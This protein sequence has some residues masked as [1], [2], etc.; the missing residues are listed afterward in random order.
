MWCRE[1]ELSCAEQPPQNHSCWLYR[2][3]EADESDLP[4]GVKQLGKS[5]WDRQTSCKQVRR[6]GVGVGGWGHQMAHQQVSFCPHWQEMDRWG[7]RL[8]RTHAKSTNAQRDKHM[9]C[10]TWVTI[11][12]ANTCCAHL[13]NADTH[14]HPRQCIGCQIATLLLFS[15]LFPGC[16]SAQCCQMAFNS[17]CPSMPCQ[18]SPHTWKPHLYTHTSTHAR[19]HQGAQRHTNLLDRHFV[20]GCNSICNIICQL[21][22][23]RLILQH[24]K[25]RHTNLLWNLFLNWHLWD[26]MGA[27]DVWTFTLLLYINM[28]P[29]LAKWSINICHQKSSQ[30]TKRNRTMQNGIEK[31]GNNWQS[32]SSSSF[33][34]RYVSKEVLCNTVL[35]YSLLFFNLVVKLGN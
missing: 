13:E 26:F 29:K 16:I 35:V 2:F 14:T 7:A 31:R 17:N 33:I 25:Y 10:R 3:Y 11:Y 32:F 6:G 9:D 18:A 22:K 15:L 20:F 8:L 12:A 30:R 1:D 23:V 34:V 28:F 19:I 4:S 27:A 21:L 24:F 5:E